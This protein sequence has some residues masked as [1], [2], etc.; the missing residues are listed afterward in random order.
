MPKGATWI[1][2]WSGK[3]FDGGQTIERSVPIDLIPLFIK[4][5]SILPIGPF[6]QYSGEK[7]ADNLEIRIYKGANGA[8]TLYEDENDNYNYE[9]GIYSLIRFSWDDA[10]KVLTIAKRQGD[11][12][13]ML[14]ERIFNIVFVSDQNGTGMN[15]SKSFK[16]V[17]YTGQKISVKE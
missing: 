13:G 3:G 8:F 7:N 9:K 15:E 5:G 1:D 12:P 10:N 14:V 11:F 2:F 4:A 6:Q 16:K 17:K